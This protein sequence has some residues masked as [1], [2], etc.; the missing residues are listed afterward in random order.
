M[1]K[2]ISWTLEYRKPDKEVVIR[3]PAAEMVDRRPDAEVVD[4]KPDKEVAIRR[5]EAEVVDRKP[6]AELAAGQLLPGH[7]VT[8]SSGPVT[9]KLFLFGPHEITYSFWKCF[10]KASPS[11]VNF[12]DSP[13][14]APRMQVEI[15]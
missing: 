9:V 6:D 13:H 14:G 4:R 1:S 8:P 5:P 10:H 11:S 7:P 15:I 12:A 3:R 2:S